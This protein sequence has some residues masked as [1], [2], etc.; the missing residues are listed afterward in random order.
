MFILKDICEEFKHYIF[1]VYD[2]VTNLFYSD[3]VP[4]RSAHLPW[5]P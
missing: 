1:S 2:K 3:F 5:R 4:Y